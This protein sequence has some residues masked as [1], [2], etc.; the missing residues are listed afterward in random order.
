MGSFVSSYILTVICKLSD[1]NPDHDFQ[2]L[3][4]MY[5]H[6]QIIWAAKKGLAFLEQFPNWYINFGSLCKEEDET[7]NVEDLL[8]TLLN[9]ENDKTEDVI[10]ILN[11]EENFET[12]DLLETLFKEENHENT[13]NVEEQAQVRN[14]F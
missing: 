5:G 12:E 14:I 9:E 3:D 2:N 8:E 6:L 7:I 13:A 10:E 4:Y 1:L 11:K